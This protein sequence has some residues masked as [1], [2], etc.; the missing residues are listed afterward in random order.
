MEGVQAA[1]MD[2]S[3]LI[4]YNGLLFL[5]IFWRFARQDVAPAPGV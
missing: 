5:I 2:L 1:F 4:L 3:L